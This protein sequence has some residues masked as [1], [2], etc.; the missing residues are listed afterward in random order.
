MSYGTEP[1]H[2]YSYQLV[3]CVS[4]AGKV[5]DTKLSVATVLP[6]FLKRE[7]DPQKVLEVPVHENFANMTVR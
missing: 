2:A 4:S 5:L 1:P 7:V 3:V 6:S